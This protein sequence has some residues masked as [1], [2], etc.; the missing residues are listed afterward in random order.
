MTFFAIASLYLAI[1]Q[2]AISTFF[3]RIPNSQFWLFLATVIKYLAILSEFWFFFSKL[4]IYK[5]SNYFS[6]LWIYNLRVNILKFCVYFSQLH[7][8]ILQFWGKTHNFVFFSELQVNVAIILR[9]FFLL[10]WVCL[11]FFC[12]FIILRCSISPSLFLFFKLKIWREIRMLESES[13]EC[14]GWS[15]FTFHV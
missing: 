9:H 14:S 2:L 11:Q 15:L 3:L 12:F 13:G 10:L 7:I 5:N 4:Q 1:F 8:Y 6:Q